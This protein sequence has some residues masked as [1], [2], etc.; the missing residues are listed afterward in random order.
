MHKE[1]KHEVS[2]QWLDARRSYLTASDILKLIPDYKRIIAGK[3]PIERAQQ[4]AKVYGSKRSVEINVESYGPMARGHILEPYAIDEYNSIG[5][6]TRVWWWD[7]KIIHNGILGFSPDALDIMPLPGINMA[8]MANK[9]DTINGIQSQPT[10][11]VEVKCYD[12]G[13]HYQRRVAWLSGIDPDERW[14]V[15]CA[16]AVCECIQS[17]DIL[18]Y[19]P[20]C[21]NMWVASYERVELE[22][23]I[24]TVNAIASLWCEFVRIMNS[25]SEI[26]TEK[27]EDDIYNRYLLDEMGR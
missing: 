22:Q 10:H 18:F 6:G 19:A 2:A 23:E 3:I 11:L 12:A 20:Q 17:G 26:A 7:D 21:R 1:W 27:T 14:Q 8:V 24:S 13:T 5:L 4:F 9:I 16:M 15:A 25:K